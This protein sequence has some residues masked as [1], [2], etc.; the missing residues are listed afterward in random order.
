MQAYFIGLMS[1]TSADGIDASL[2][3]IDDGQLKS[4]GHFYLPFDFEF[5]QKLLNLYQPGYNE[6]EISGPLAVELAVRYANAVNHL[7][8]HTHLSSADISAIGCHGQTI[9]HRPDGQNP[10]TMQICDYAKLAEL[11]RIDVIGDFRSADIAA[12]GQGAPLVPAF[13]QTIFPANERDQVVV[14]IGGIA[15]MTLIRSDSSIIGFDTGPGNGLMDEWC[16]LHS[17]QAYDENGHWAAGGQVIPSLLTELLEQPYFYQQGP[18]S[19]GREVFNL[20]WLEAY[21]KPEYTARDVQASLL[22]LTCE[23]IKQSIVKHS[24]SA[25]VWICGGGAHN[26]ALMETLAAIL[27]EPYSLNSTQAINIDPDWIESDCFAWLAYCFMNRIPANIPA[28]T[29]ASR[30]KVLGCL[31][32]Y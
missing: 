21:L 14:N 31:Y 23:S 22:K 1:G 11:T 9:R 3:K 15:N 4:V 12:G 30:Q 19:S 6:I 13:H 5:K 10:F 17:N 24:A 18:K 26:Q 8:I 32:P 29:G 27:G 25:D 20:S 28:V 2:I 7:L 16:Q